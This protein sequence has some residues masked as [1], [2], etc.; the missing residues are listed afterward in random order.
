MVRRKAV[1]II[2]VV[3]VVDQVSK[4]WVKTNMH[5]DESI[6]VFGDWFFIHF[7]ENPGMAFG[8]EFGGQTGKLLLSLFRI[9]AI[10]F[11]WIYMSGL[12]KKNAPKGLIISV[13]LV[14]AG[15]A[16]NIIDSAFYGVIF[17]ESPPL[18]VLATMFPESGGYASLL[19]G[20]VVDMLY[21]PIIDT[22]WPEWVPG[23]GGDRL[24]FFR[25]IFNI[26]DSSITIGMALILI[27]QKKYFKEEKSL[28]KVK[29]EQNAE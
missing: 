7:I 12:I 28:D 11:I 27:N 25:P 29:A 9:V 15:A 18:P 5:L 3:L 13:A 21:F 24:Q 22:Y 17:S 14:F 23:L 8:L 26:A 10:V 19:Q 6:T 16:G 1:L 4:I 20:K 2:L